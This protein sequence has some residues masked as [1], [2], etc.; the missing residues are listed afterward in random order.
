MSSSIEYRFY[1]I[2]LRKSRSDMAWKKI[3]TDADL[4]LIKEQVQHGLPEGL[5]AVKM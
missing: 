3:F 5:Y 1:D 4:V 2:Q